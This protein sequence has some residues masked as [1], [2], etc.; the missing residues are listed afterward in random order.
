MRHIPLFLVC[1]FPVKQEFQVTMNIH[2]A[3]QTTKK[4]KA[5]KLKKCIAP[6]KIPMLSTLLI[7]YLQHNPP[8]LPKKLPI[9][10]VQPKRLL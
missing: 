3:L 9:T 10:P 5:I 1:L 7:F 8:P 2:R 4:D 6:E